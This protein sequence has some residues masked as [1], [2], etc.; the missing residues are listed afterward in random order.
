MHT[1]CDDPVGSTH[2]K[3]TLASPAQSGC[4]AAGPA[5]AIVATAPTTAAAALKRILATSA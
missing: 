3:N 2:R 5:I 4:A 1:V